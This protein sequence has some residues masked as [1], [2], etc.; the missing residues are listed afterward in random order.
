[1][2]PARKK[3]LKKLNKKNTNPTVRICQ[4]GLME[5]NSILYLR[6]SMLSKSLSVEGIAGCTAACTKMYSQSIFVQISFDSRY[7]GLTWI[8][9]KCHVCPGAF[10]L[11]DVDMLHFEGAGRMIVWWS[12]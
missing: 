8:S 9:D 1:M 6:R 2:W 5:R 3:V 12:V 11:E 7:C 10:H 4:N